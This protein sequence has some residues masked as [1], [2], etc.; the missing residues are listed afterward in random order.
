MA[1]E[2]GKITLGK[3]RKYVLVVPD[4][5]QYPILGYVRVPMDYQG[6]AKVVRSKADKLQESFHE[7]FEG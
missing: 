6:G 7:Q 3:P 2:N 1:E 4:E 5:P